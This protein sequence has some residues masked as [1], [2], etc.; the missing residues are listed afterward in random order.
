MNF[1]E[2]IRRGVEV[3]VPNLVGLS[4]V[5]VAVNL[6]VLP[7]LVTVPL[8]TVPAVIGGLWT[9]CLL[10]GVALVG[11]FRFTTTVADRGVAVAVVPHLVAAVKRPW[12]GFGLGAVT[13]V[14][15]LGVLLT[16]LAPGEF[17][18]VAV[19]AGAFVV[20]CWYLVVAFA[21][22]ELGAGSSARPAIRS[23]AVRFA[24]SPVAAV[25]FLLLSI[26]CTAV[27]G[28]TVVTLVL[29]LPG[30]LG[31]FAVTVAVD[32]ADPDALGDADAG[33]EN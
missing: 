18:A 25:S 14:V 19:G 28:V 22:P 32:I 3:G 21:A 26:L 29:F 24:Q 8:G 7:F 5:S 10:F 16:G 20:V 33:S 12:V 31:L 4:V 13:F 9:T 11:L 6:T 15:I 2:T 23:G 17:R 30:V 27:A 1:A